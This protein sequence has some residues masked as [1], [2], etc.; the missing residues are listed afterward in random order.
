[1]A[2][3][4]G[5]PSV[6]YGQ[7][8]P[9]YGSVAG[10]AAGPGG[11]KGWARTQAAAPLNYAPQSYA[12]PQMP[13]YNMGGYG[14]YHQQQPSYNMGGY[15]YQQPSYAP[16]QY[17]QGAYNQNNYNLP[18]VQ[19][20]NQVRVSRDVSNFFQPIHNYF[21]DILE[22]QQNTYYQPVNYL[23]QIIK[24]IPGLSQYLPEQNITQPIQYQGYDN[25]GMGGYGQQQQY[26]G[27]DMSALLGGYGQQQQ[28]GGGNDIASLLA[29]LGIAG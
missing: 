23:Q 28:Y 22:K 19:G 6:S 15:G 9:G 8:V 2:Y 7:P 20:Q 29:Q 18:P 12:P 13:A 11:A 27:Y 16:P 24:Q 4:I 21:T 17:I 3:Q 10:A 5:N 14:G 26:G 25:Y 1:M